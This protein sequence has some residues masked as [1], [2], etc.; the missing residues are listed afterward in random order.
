VRSHKPHP[1]FRTDRTLTCRREQS[2]TRTCSNIAHFVYTVA[3]FS[4]TAHMSMSYGSDTALEPL[5]SAVTVTRTTHDSLENRHCTADNYKFCIIRICWHEFCKISTCIILYRGVG[6][7][8][9]PLGNILLDAPSSEWSMCHF[10]LML[11]LNVKFHVT[12]IRVMVLRGRIKNKGAYYV[13]N[14]CDHPLCK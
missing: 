8:H 1:V 9:P 6:H 2:W 12:Y 5:V 4:E 14:V 11:S 7:S 3:W 10:T 13:E